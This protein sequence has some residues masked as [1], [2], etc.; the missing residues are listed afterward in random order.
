MA[1]ESCQYRQQS[2]SAEEQFDGGNAGA[3]VGDV[4]VD[5]RLLSAIAAVTVTQCCLAA[6]SA[7]SSSACWISSS[8]DAAACAS[9]G[10]TSAGLIATLPF[11]PLLSVS[12]AIG[13]SVCV[14]RVRG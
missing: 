11:R 3:D 14:L 10:R 4:H 9:A 2:S 1:S 13:F 7:A 8:E 12:T 5:A 6:P